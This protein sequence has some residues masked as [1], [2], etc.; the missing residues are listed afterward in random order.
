MHHYFDHSGKK[1]VNGNE[2]MIRLLIIMAFILLT[3]FLKKA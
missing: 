2:L 1:S 3:Y